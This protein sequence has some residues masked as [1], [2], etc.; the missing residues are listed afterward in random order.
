MA[1]EL[2]TSADP[3]RRTWRSNLPDR[4][5]V[6]GVITAG[7]YV[8][9]AQFGFRFAFAAE[10]VTTVWAPTGIGMAALLLWGP[11]LWPAIWAGAFIAN[12]A[13]NAPL[14]TAASVATGNTLE[15]VVTCYLTR[16]AGFDPR[17]ERA[18]DVLAFIVIGAGAS[19][20]ISATIGVTTLCMAGVQPLSRFVPLWADWWLGDAVGALVVCPVILTMA[21]HGPWSTR[22]LGEG[23]V[24]AGGAM[25]AVHAVFGRAL[26]SAQ[27]THPTE[28]VIFP[29]VVAGAVRGGPAVTAVVVLGA[30]AVAIAHTA[31]GSGPFA[32]NVHEGMRLLQTF[33]GVLAGTGLLLAAAIAERAVGE[34]R[35]AA[36]YAVGQVLARAPH[37]QA[38]APVLLREL[39]ATLEWQ[40]GG[41]WLVGADGHLHCIEIWSERGTPVQAFEDISRRLAFAPG[42]GLPGRVLATG[43]AA[44]IEDV[45]RDPNF[46]RADA[47]RA[48]G[49][50]GGFAF[51]VSLG[52]QV[53][54]VIECFNRAVVAPD[55]DLLRTMSMVGHQVGQ[56]VARK[57][58]QDALAEEQQRTSA[59]RRDAEAANR[60]KDEFLAT[61]SHELR[62]PLNAILG[63]TRMLLDGVVDPAH[64]R[65]GL[66]VI[67]RN[68]RLQARLV[69]DILD[70]SRIITG[71]LTLEARPLDP[72]PVVS[73]ALDAMRPAAR[74]K[75]VQLQAELPAGAPF[76]MAD[77]QRLQQIVWNLLANAVKFTG[78]GGTIQVE[79]ADV[80]PHAIEIRVH[81]DG[82]GIEPASLPHVFERFWQADGSIS[83]AHGGLGLGLAIVRH[84]TEL[85]GG[86]VRAESRGRGLGATFI[87]ELPKATAEATPAAAEPR[88][89]EGGG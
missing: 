31:S 1:A 76:V 21:R 51:P 69:E 49:V 83:R 68:A 89:V 62:T 34:R 78:S 3:G 2:P 63:W 33:V 56:F 43:H 61:L 80:G 10:Q 19:T 13:T 58:E 17:L 25:A 41:M 81:D 39:C 75:N 26:V 54:G 52:D 74:A 18:R 47:A 20:M 29:F 45:T 59:A 4:R 55:D 11:A 87:V 64:A 8:A 86:S 71:G 42:A 46:P 28:Y 27:A 35:R 48:A 38:A 22:K 88:A 15:A 32:G 84:L 6:I 67:D 23:V 9:A 36:A 70:V 40:I 53:L 77:P 5:V 12:A 30:T 44:W 14:W 7:V 73:L 65:R 66:E 37:L 79:L 16:A 60:A 85:H 50:H 57:R 24:L 82:A 72:T